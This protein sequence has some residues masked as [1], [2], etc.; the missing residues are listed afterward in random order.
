MSSNI[1]ALLAAAQGH[2]DV[3]AHGNGTQEQGAASPQEGRAHLGS[4]AARLSMSDNPHGL[5]LHRSPASAQPPSPKSGIDSVNPSVDGSNTN[6]MYH[7]T[8]STS[9]YHSPTQGHSFG[10]H[11]A[12]AMGVERSQ[13]GLKVA[14]NGISHMY[15]HV[16]PAATASVSAGS[17]PGSGIPPITASR[18]F[19]PVGPSLSHSP[20]HSPQQGMQMTESF[21][22]T[23]SFAT[24][25]GGGGTSKKS[26]AAATHTIADELAEAVGSKKDRKR[27]RVHYSCAEC[28]RRKHKCDR[29]IPCKPCVDRGIGAVCR[30]F[31]EGDQH[32]DVRDRVARLEDIVEG[33]ALAQT[34]MAR[35]LAYAKGL[36]PPG[37]KVEDE[38]GAAADLVGLAGLATAPGSNGGSKSVTGKAQDRSIPMAQPTFSALRRS[39][40]DLGMDGSN[41]DMDN[42]I[43][44][45]EQDHHGA[46]R[47]RTANNHH[48]SSA[49]SSAARGR[50]RATQ[51]SAAEKNDPDAHELEIERRTLDGQFA[52]DG[53]SW[54]GALALPS[55]SRGVIETEIH[56]EK[57][58]LGAR[59]PKYP[60]SHKLN[61]LI[62]EGGAPPDIL[63][64]LMSGLPP[65]CE[66]D[67]LLE[68]YFRDINCTRLPI[69]E[70]DFRQSYEDLMEFRWGDAEERLGDD[71]ARHLPFLSL[72]Y[73][74]LA[75]ARQANAENKETFESAKTGATRLYHLCRK[76]TLVASVIR[77]DHIDLVLTHLFTAR[78]LT[79]QR[80]SAEAWSQLGTTI[81]AA[82]AIGLHRDGSKL[83]MDG[84]T[85]ERRRRI[86]ALIFWMD[87]TTSILLGRPQAIQEM[88]CDTLPPSDI[89]I[90]TMPRSTKPLPPK[91]PCQDP[92]S[93]PGVYAYVAIR[94]ELTKLT[95][96]IVEHFQNLSSPR[97]YS[98]CLRLDEDLEKFQKSLP[99]P[100][101]SEALGGIDR[102]FDKICP[103]LPLHRYLLNV[104][105][106]Y[107]RIALHRP[108]VLRNSDKYSQS[109]K[110][111]FQSAKM[112]RLIRQEYHREVNWSSDRARK[113]HMG[114]L[115]R[116]FNATMM[117]GVALLLDPNSSEAPELLAILD[118]FI[119]QHRASD[120]AD[121]C[122]K[123]EVKIIELFRAKAQDPSWCAATA[124]GA[125]KRA[126]AQRARTTTPKLGP[127]VSS[128]R[129]DITPTKKASTVGPTAAGTVAGLSN[130]STPPDESTT[131][132]NDN[133]LA[134]TIFDQLGGLENFGLYQNSV[135]PADGTLAPQPMTLDLNGGF[136]EF[137]TF[138]S[139]G[140]TAST[141]A[142]PETK[143]V[144]ASTGMTPSTS[145][146]GCAFGSLDT[147]SSPATGTDMNV[148]GKGAMNVSFPPG[149]T[150]APA[151]RGNSDDSTLIP[152]GG[153]IEAIAPSNQ[154]IPSHSH[155]GKR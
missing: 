27:K 107:V 21:S 100:Y 68:L 40:E 140:P 22:T 99:P 125:R 86:W 10:Q 56:G 94:H 43:P 9:L 154:G 89:D 147:L 134:Q 92:K 7:K 113:V 132:S 77:V 39:Q 32:G 58:E 137:I 105:Y 98:D 46:K 48:S 131:S 6:G 122:S 88:H 127:P 63:D 83:G 18:A 24:A 29:K 54:F 14:T 146:V 20:A 142:P 31:E 51:V 124:T 69:H 141:P 45:A 85:T 5:P 136:D 59:M 16:R 60:A 47:T 57:L 93:P 13:P 15:Q 151:S 144:K 96:Q 155:V 62:Y 66:T 152:W 37:T 153:L 148:F 11:L 112:D 104:E 111:A 145:Q 36:L 2:G 120:L 150:L 38:P 28:H 76:C 70:A 82:Q 73:S 49:T 97:K 106:H 126:N 80:Q 65:R 34:A 12:G 71:G 61:R 91:P 87:K 19:S 118:E 64:E 3:R 139:E 123:R 128:M 108:Y 78:F 116:L 149:A 133:D 109:R 110:A 90:D 33:L 81:R 67:S 4:V 119:E 138:W 55:V 74:I 129:T 130:I 114:G 25:S 101:R 1:Q 135:P 23:S 102:S 75:I 42:D 26:K 52:N 117:I 84:V 79:V 35:E 41:E 95:G 115:Y 103:W 143:D 44:F 72:L 121:F 30:P 53:D 50:F 17:A 8:P